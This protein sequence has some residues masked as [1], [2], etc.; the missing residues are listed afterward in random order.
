MGII[1]LLPDFTRERMNDCSDVLAKKYLKSVGSIYGSTERGDPNHIGSCVAVELDGCR[2]LITAAHVIDELQYTHL[3]VGGATKTVPI[4]REFHGTSAHRA[5]RAKD[6]LDFA[7]I[8]LSEKTKKAI[9]GI[10]Y[11]CEKDM[12]LRDLSQHQRC[13]L[14]LGYP[15]SKN[16]FKRRNGT[17]L[18]ETPFIYTSTLEYDDD[19]YARV[20]ANKKNH[21]LLDYS[22]KQSRDMN[23][24]IVNS[25]YSQGVSGGGLFFVP[26]MA[27]PDSYKP[28]AECTGKLIGILT[29]FKKGANI[30]LYTKLSTIITSI[31]TSVQ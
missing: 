4:S 29:T 17:I 13:G 11:I 8:K 15:N 18:K 3:Y 24:R 16:K 1:K 14:A 21:Y 20:G 26:G 25:I 12:L 9:G 22:R 23:G 19:L 7:V 6:N 30:L 2:Y 27:T 5:D 31:R 28:D 10:N